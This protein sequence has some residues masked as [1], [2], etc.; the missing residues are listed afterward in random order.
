[1]ANLPWIMVE[2]Y[3]YPTGW[4]GAEQQ[5]ARARREDEADQ[6]QPEQRHPQ[7]RQRP[8]RDARRGAARPEPKSAVGPRPSAV[9]KILLKAKAARFRSP[10][11][12]KVSSW[13]IKAGNRAL[14]RH[15]GPRAIFGGVAI[16]D[17]N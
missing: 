7:P 1:M 2:D 11:Q 9:G 8:Q 5:E 12:G 6:Q 16:I 17:S 10:A 15:R 4:V 14:V 3:K 13:P